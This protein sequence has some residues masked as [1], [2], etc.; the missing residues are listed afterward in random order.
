MIIP[1]GERYQQNLYRLTKQGRTLKREPLQA[2]LFVPMTGTAE[3][4]RRVQPDPLR[5]Q[6]RNG[7]FED[8][9]GDSQQPAGWHYLRQARIMEGRSA[10]AGDRWLT[11]S[12]RDP[13]RASQ[14]LQGLALDGRKL[15]RL[16]VSC[17]VRGKEIAAGLDNSHQAALM[18]NFYDQRRAVIDSAQLG[19]WSGT[20]DWRPIVEELRVPLGTREAILRIGLHGATG[21]LD[22]DAIDISAI[23]AQ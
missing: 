22:V 3:D 8:A 14:A 4:A 18:V 20:F 19:P 1:V 5:P 17:Q 9:V 23:A 21:D 2:T 12:N 7:G 10:P 11:F 16:R 6:V 15:A 13:G